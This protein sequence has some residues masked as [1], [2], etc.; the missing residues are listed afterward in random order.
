MGRYV[1]T[2]GNSGIGLEIGRG[3]VSKGH[4]VVLL[5]R[6]TQKCEARGAAPPPRRRARAPSTGG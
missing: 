1:I 2:G 3:L 6:S 5:G 4:E